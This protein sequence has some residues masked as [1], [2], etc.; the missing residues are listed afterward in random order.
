MSVCHPESA[1]SGYLLFFTTTVGVHKVCHDLRDHHPSTSSYYIFSLQ[2]RR[3]GKFNVGDLHFLSQNEGGTNVLQ[4]RSPPLSPSRPQWRHLCPAALVLIG[5]QCCGFSFHQGS[6]FSPLPLPLPLPLRSAPPELAEADFAELGVR[7]DEVESAAQQQ[8]KPLSGEA[9]RDNDSEDTADG[10]ASFVRMS[11]VGSEE[12]KTPSAPLPPAADSLGRF[13]TF[14]E[15]RDLLFLRNGVETVPT[16]EIGMDLL[17]VWDAEARRGGGAGPA[18]AAEIGHG[19]GGEGSCCSVLQITTELGLPGLRLEAHNTIGAK[20]IL[21]PLKSSQ[22]YPEYQFTL[23][24]SELRPRGPK[25]IVWLFNKLMA[26][27]GV[28]SSFTRVRVEDVS[29]EVNGGEGRQ[30]MI[31]FVTD[32]RLQ[33][34]VQL[35]RGAMRALPGV[36]AARFERQG[37]R[38]VQKMLEKELEPALMEFYAAYLRWVEAQ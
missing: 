20:L 31:R 14:D 18:T 16:C 1:P 12:V 2:E 3:S 7:V 24:N 25:P 22:L 27:R 23:L 34:R 10:F 9:D 15:H 38:S 5:H 21:P 35:T 4:M 33:V 19:C 32:A 26:Y 36:N 37:S 30:R 13:F 28:T 6:T 11:L 29:E 17:E 8:R